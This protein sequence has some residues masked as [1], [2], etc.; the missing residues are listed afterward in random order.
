MGFVSLEKDELEKRTNAHLSNQMIR[1][2]H[3]H[4][5]NIPDDFRRK[6]V[7]LLEQMEL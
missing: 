5:Y 6:M 4:N 3:D 7:R 1:L 2:L